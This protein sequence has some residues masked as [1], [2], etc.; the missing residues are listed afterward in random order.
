MWATILEYS[1]ALSVRKTF[2]EFE[3]SSLTS[4]DF[5]VFNICEGEKR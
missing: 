4:I 3:D 2:W 5:E 1:L